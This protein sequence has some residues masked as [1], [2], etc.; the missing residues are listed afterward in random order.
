MQKLL[1]A[2]TEAVPT[3]E[4]NFPWDAEKKSIFLK[5][6]NF[7]P[8]NNLLLMLLRQ[9]K[10]HAILLFLFFFF[11][12]V[13]CLFNIYFLLLPSHAILKVVFTGL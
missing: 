1:I 8:K 3:E 11:L 6:G 7:Q 12:M 2:V 13:S 4:V 5:V 9:T 10:S